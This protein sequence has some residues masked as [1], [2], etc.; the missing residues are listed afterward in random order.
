MGR[1]PVIEIKTRYSM[2]SYNKFII[3]LI[4]ILPLISLTA[5]SDFNESL[6]FFQEES[7]DINKTA[8]MV[9]GSWAAGNI[10]TGLYGNFS[11]DGEKKY[12]HQFNAMWN[13]V[14]LAIAVLGYIDA[15]DVSGSY[16]NL[17][18][19]RDYHF[20]QNFLLLNAGLDIAYIATGFYL[21]ERSKNSKKRDQLRGYGNSLLL[22]G[23]FLLA[24]DIALYF[25]HQG[26][27]DINLYP[28][29]E[30]FLSGGA[31]MGMSIRF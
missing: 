28:H 17:D 22:Q 14:N 20:L 25:I 5:Q 15:A 8:M 18:I 11:T 9:L 27:A 21:R 1:E 24:F 23:G 3:F 30:S 13:S 26:N 4:F 7:K 29:M 19:I 16:S 2:K 12:F 31:G 6:R 10:L